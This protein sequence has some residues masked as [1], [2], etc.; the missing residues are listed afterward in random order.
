MINEHKKK[1]KWK[2]NKHEIL[3]KENMVKKVFV[4]FVDINLILKLC[5]SVCEYQYAN[6][7]SHSLKYLDT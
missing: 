7:G 2:L 6:F 3:D 1:W 5:V 4:V